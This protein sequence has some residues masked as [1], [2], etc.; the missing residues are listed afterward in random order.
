MIL[1]RK[2]TMEHFSEVLHFIAGLNCHREFNNPWLGSDEATIKDRL[3]SLPYIP[4]EEAF[5]LAFEEERLVGVL[6]FAA[7]PETGQFRLLGPYV[8]HENWNEISLALYHQVLETIPDTYATCRV[9]IDKL[10]AQCASLFQELGFAE[11]NAEALLSLE[12]SRYQPPTLEPLS[13][14]LTITPYTDQFQEAFDKL[15]P[16]EAY[17]SSND[18]INQLSET[19]KMFILCRD[20]SELIGYTYVE[21]IPENSTAEICFLR[22]DEIHRNKQYGT[23]LIAYVIQWGQEC[24]GIEKLELSVRIANIHARRLYDRLNFDETAVC[25]SLE[26]QRA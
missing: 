23:H 1:Y 7:F 6:G 14:D 13:S 8:Q 18:I 26:K 15:H 20:G 16:K 21:A 11:Y 24:Q 12:L 25:V 17:F 2:A 9:S 10:N 22:V 3:Q 5:F 4:F 19:K